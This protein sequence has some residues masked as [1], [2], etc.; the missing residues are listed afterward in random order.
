MGQAVSTN[1][2]VS[3]SND[4]T[5]KRILEY[6]CTGRFIMFSVITNI[7]DKK[8]KGRTLMEFFT[9]TRKLIFFNN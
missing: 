8:T 1:T 2:D 3:A 6:D 5:E 9:A 7:Y 4:V